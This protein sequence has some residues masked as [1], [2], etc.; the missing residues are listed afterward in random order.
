MSVTYRKRQNVFLKEET[1]WSVE[2]DA[3]RIREPA[4]PEERLLWCNVASVR[5][6]YAPTRLKR[7]R[8]VFVVYLKDGRK[9]EIDNAHFAGVGQ[10]E[11]YS[12]T[13]VP[14]VRAALERI[15]IHAPEAKARAGSGVMSYVLNLLFVSTTFCLLAFVL[16]VI[17][18]PLDY[19]SFSSFVKAG[20]IIVFLPALIRWIR[21]ARPRGMELD[22]IPAD[23]LPNLPVPAAG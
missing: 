3:L 6:A 4:R 16:M 17:P 22:E 18:T 5:L 13:Y 21:K 8:Y 12:S 9:V 10:F 15:R 14:F 23:A 1:E 19:L 2:E 20:I 7:W 11:D